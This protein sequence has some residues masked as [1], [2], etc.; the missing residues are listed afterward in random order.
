MCGI[1]GLVGKTDLI[2]EQMSDCI[3]HRGPDGFGYWR[4]PSSPTILAH[5]RLAILDPESGHQPMVS[6]DG[7]YVITFNGEIYNF[8][9]LRNELERQGYRFITEC[10][11]EVVLAGY[12]FY[13]EQIVEKLRGMFAFGIWDAKK[14]VLFLARDR[15][16]IKPLFYRLFPGGLAFAS[17]TKALGNRNVMLNARSLVD[18]LRLGFRTSNETL[19]ESIYE[20]SPATSATYEYGASS[21]LNVTKYWNLPDPTE[22][23]GDFEENATRLAK[24]V[25]SASKAHLLSDVPLGFWLSGGLDSSIILSCAK[26]AIPEDSRMAFTLAYGLP[27]D[28]TPYAQA[29][30]KA[31]GVNWH[32]FKADLRQLKESIV[33]MVWHLEEPLPNVSALTTFLLAQ[34]TRPFTKVVLIGE[35]SDELFGGYPHYMPFT[36]WW[37]MLPSNLQS[38]AGERAYLMP[39]MSHWSKLVHSELK[40]QIMN[41]PKV[42]A[43]ASLDEALRFDISHELVQNQLAR[44]DRLTMANSIEARVPFLDHCVVE[45]AMR[46]PDKQKR[47]GNRTKIILRKAFENVL[48]PEI[49]NRP[50]YGQK[51]TQR[52]SETLYSLVIKPL[53]LN[54]LNPE[55]LLTIGFDPVA[56]N[57]F[58]HERKWSYYQRAVLHK[59]VYFILLYDIWH[60]LFIEGET[61]EN[62]KANLHLA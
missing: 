43:R 19:L 15:L 54:M 4:S 11:T 1:A 26:D 50:K 48:P 14:E 39:S 53:A 33:D 6:Q 62:V 24:E 29:M 55:R 16:G 51:G 36:G 8:R 38:W 52:I 60:R 25:E 7:Q 57:R 10:D 37:Q 42:P 31:A 35:G 12:G 20:L 41:R 45:A 28:E 34:K 13:G 44:I 61:R 27:N 23:G 40:G 3:A 46:I 47:Q 56:I 32:L 59:T 17:E 2:I 49:T 5:R 9:E 30:A 22:A 58:M 18:Y 21:E